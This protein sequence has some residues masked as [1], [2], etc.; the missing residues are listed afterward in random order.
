MNIT[1]D[2]VTEYI[3]GFYKPLTPKLGTLRESAE[4]DRV[5]IILRDTENFLLSLMLI[6]KPSCILEI[7]AAVGYSASFFAEAYTEVKVVTIESDQEKYYT[8]RRNIEELGYLPRVKVLLGDAVEVMNKLYE[9][10]PQFDIV[11]IDASKSHYK[12]FWDSAILMCSPGSVIVSDN[13]LMKAMTVS[14]EYDF[15][16]KHK[17][18]I[19]RMR[20]YVEFIHTLDYCKT[21]VLPIGDGIAVSYII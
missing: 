9:S 8:A 18:N 2:K 16:G 21:A 3:N 14:D 15:N 20:E 17:T 10:K 1:N 12:E 19:R 13:V 11:F 5:P 6:K 4:K 7:G